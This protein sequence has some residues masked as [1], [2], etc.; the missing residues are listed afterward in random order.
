VGNA[1]EQPHF[2]PGTA[3]TTTLEQPTI[4]QPSQPQPK[5][6]RWNSHNEKRNNHVLAVPA[7]YF[8]AVP[9]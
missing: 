5:I 7:H 1:L 9:A 2:Y 8:M 4:E 6:M 3:T